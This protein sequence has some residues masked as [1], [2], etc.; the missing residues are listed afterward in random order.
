MQ[1]FLLL[2][3]L[4]DA[5]YD[6]Q[7][8]MHN[9]GYLWHLV[10]LEVSYRICSDKKMNRVSQSFFSSLV[11]TCGPQAKLHNKGYLYQLLLG[12]FELNFVMDRRRM[13]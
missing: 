12:G 3:L 2:L 4:L 10:L 1:G 9:K 13:E 11:T 6:P 5:N 8:Q 7:A